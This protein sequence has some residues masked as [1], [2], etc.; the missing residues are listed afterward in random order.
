MKIK[1]TVTYP[2]GRN[3]ECEFLST[4]VTIGRNSSNDLILDD[5]HVSREHCALIVDSNGL[6]HVSSFQSKNGLIID[7]QVVNEHFF[8]SNMSSFFIGKV[9]VEFHY[10]ANE[11]DETTIFDLQSLNDNR[12]N[13]PQ[14]SVN[15]KY[16][17]KQSVLFS[18]V[19]LFLVFNILSFT[20]IYLSQF[21]GDKEFL[22]VE[23]VGANFGIP[24]FGLFLMLFLR[25]FNKRI[26]F[27]ECVKYLLLLFSFIFF[28]Q[29]LDFFL[30]G[31][32]Q[33]LV[34]SATGLGFIMLIL[35]LKKKSISII[36]SSKKL[37]KGFMIFC[38]FS[39]VI[40]LF[41]DEEGEESNKINEINYV[42]KSKWDKKIIINRVTPF[43]F[44]S[45][46]EDIGKD[47]DFFKG[48]DSL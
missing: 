13:Q 21:M 6:V 39:I 11:N 26:P 41:L 42:Q 45:L 1:I 33:S 23:W 43:Y 37:K 3:H 19:S 30:D 47:Y 29:I 9:K 2:D 44:D 8:N 22:L 7:G 38:F 48:L 27:S 35:Y 25:L 32:F 40:F 5:G 46:K 4:K 16:H 14:T 28:I 34:D 24:F 12:D 10:L 31:K 36:P 17:K 20:E 15:L 18:Y